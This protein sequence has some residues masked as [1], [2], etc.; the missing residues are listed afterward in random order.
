[1][2]TVKLENWIQTYSGKLV[3]V[4]N[5]KPEDI[6]IIDIA[7]ALSMTCR[8]GGHSR[9]FYSVA[10]HSVRVGI[11]GSNIRDRH[12]ITYSQPKENTKHHLALLLHDAAEAYIGDIITPLKNSLGG[13]AE[14]ETKWLLAIEQKFKLETRLSDPDPSIKEADLLA[15]SIEIVNLYDHVDPI[16]W[17]KFKTPSPSNL[18]YTVECWSPSLANKKFLATFN[19]LRAQLGYSAW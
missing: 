18:A 14:L 2:A 11:I 15:L 19:H 9:D 10:E 3:S 12:N 5:P 7:H 17:S 16:W 1:M 13:A 8:F 4:T 6:D